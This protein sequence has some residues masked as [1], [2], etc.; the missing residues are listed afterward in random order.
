MRIGKTIG[1]VTLS[2]WHPD[3]AGGRYRLAVPQS[4]ANLTGQSSEATE[5]FVVYDEFGVGNDMLIA[6]TE[7][8]EAAQPFHPNTKPIDAYNAAILDQVDV[9]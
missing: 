2:R 4:L 1:Y 3:L 6:I 5:E 9:R 7:G 8:P